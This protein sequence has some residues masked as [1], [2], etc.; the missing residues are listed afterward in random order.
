MTHP[1]TEQLTAYLSNPQSCE[2]KELSLHLAVCESCRSEVSLLTAI[3]SNAHELG[4]GQKDEF[5]KTD[6]HLKNIDEQKIEEYVDNLLSG[7]EKQNRES[8]IKNNPLALKAALHYATHSSAMERG[9]QCLNEPAVG[10]NLQW[11]SK[12]SESTSL[13]NSIKKFLYPP[14]WVSVPVTA[15]AVTILFFVITPGFQSESSNMT[16]ASYQD[17]AVIHFMQTKQTP[18]IGFF[19][20]ANKT[21]KPFGNVRINLVDHDTVAISW[22]EI[23]NAGFY[24]IGLQMF[25]KG[26]KIIIS[27][28]TTTNNHIEIKGLKAASNRRYE[29]ILS[30][31]TKEGK[32]FHAT[33][34]FV[35]KKR[36]N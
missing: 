7:K 32:T 17:N 27:E 1:E 20:K 36:N 35:I 22:P 18:G 28:K 5:I 4:S 12:L 21:T 25:D 11:A 29:W 14:V 30:G 23:E 3:K 33:G 2:F 26:D 24:T 31:E 10:E 15:A 6:S 16:I 9:L 19:S 34:G 13:F 8:A